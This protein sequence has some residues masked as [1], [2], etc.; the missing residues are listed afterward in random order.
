MEKKLLDILD[1]M[2]AYALRMTMNPADAE[3]IVQDACVRAL[4]YG[5]EDIGNF[6]S[7]A[8][9]ILHNCFVDYLKSR[10]KHIHLDDF[11]ADLRPETLDAMTSPALETQ[12]FRNALSG[13]VEA[14]LRELPV[15]IREAVALCD[16]EGL[17]IRDA[18]TA[19]EVPE[20]TVKSRLWRGRRFLYNELYEY[21]R[22]RGFAG[23]AK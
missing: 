11:N 17:S 21:A 15:P 7:W 23:D 12:L 16:I 19:L 4:K 6:K 3:D 22:Q 13:D 14:A 10:K 9:K 8:F 18:A 2:Y 5:G 1:G 20:G